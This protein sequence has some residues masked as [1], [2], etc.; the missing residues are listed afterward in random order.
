MPRMEEFRWFLLGFLAFAVGERL[1]ERRFSQQARRGEVKMLWSYVAFHILHALIYVGTGVELFLRQSAPVYPVVVVGLVL[2]G[3]SLV[4][5][6]AAIR[7]LGRYWSLNLEIRKDHQL[8]REGLYRYMRHP[9]YAAIMLEVVSIPLVGNAWW[10]LALSVGVYIP[11][12]LARWRREEREMIT[13]FGVEYEE[14]RRQVYAFVPLRRL[15]SAN[16]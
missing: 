6:L 14:Y 10:T 13:K 1:Y 15:E 3:V 11:L 2:F 16:R 8:V 12:L 5:R 7:T 9:A 4:I